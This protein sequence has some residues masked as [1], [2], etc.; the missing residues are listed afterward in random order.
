MEEAKNEYDSMNAK[1]FWTWQAQLN[2]ENSIQKLKGKITDLEH[3]LNYQKMHDE[4]LHR[5][6][7][8]SEKEHQKTLKS[9][10]EV[11][12]DHKEVS[13]SRK[14]QMIELAALKKLQEQLSKDLLD[15]KAT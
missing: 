9:Y 6:F 11:Q 2:M 7:T 5:K 8:E 4:T 13:G 3:N 10:E 12:A 1:Q 14:S 15:K